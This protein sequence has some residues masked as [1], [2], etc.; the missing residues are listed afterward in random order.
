MTTPPMHPIEE[1]ALRRVRANLLDAMRADEAMAAARRARK[2]RRR[3]TVL[4][5]GVAGALTAAVLAFV[6][7]SRPHDD[8]DV[9]TVDGSIVVTT[10][11]P[12]TTAAPA[13]VPRTTTTVAP[14]PPAPTDFVAVT[15]D[16]RLVVVDVATQTEI[17]ELARR[18]DPRAPVS[19]EMAP[20][21]ISGVTVDRAN[22]LVYYETC[23]EP[24]A[25]DVWSVPLDG[26]A[27][28]T[29]V[30]NM[31][32]PAVSADGSR[33][34]GLAAS[35]LWVLDA[36]THDI[37]SA[38]DDQFGFHTAISADGSRVAYER[39]YA[40]GDRVGSEIVLIDTADLAEGTGDAEARAALAN[41][42]VL[43]D[44]ERVGWM[45]PAFNRDGNLVVAQQCCYGDLHVGPRA[46]R[47]LD[48]ATGDVVGS[49]SYPASIVDQEYDSS[50]TW[51]VVTLADG[52]VVWLGGGRSGDLGAGYLAADW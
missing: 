49:F 47:V 22:G 14:P 44:P 28:S 7:V 20:N 52:R 11:T 10:E 40:D 2:A 39:T 32:W 1:E 45:F 38:I 5:V 48:P 12:T 50:G 21:S 30:T 31:S 35:F 6:V 26:S 46:A 13:A 51:L 41:A 24:A 34:A 15:T 23:C 17:R 8:S 3:L 36:R 43:R 27:E 37:R 33:I 16:G 29:R 9:H 25:G 19:G 18:A 4:G 42:R